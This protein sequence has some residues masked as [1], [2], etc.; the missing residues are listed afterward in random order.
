MNPNVALL[1]LFAMG[2]GSLGL[3]YWLGRR[4][5][6]E[7]QVA[8]LCVGTWGASCLSGVAFRLFMASWGGL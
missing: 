7:G 6:T 5:S 4:G 3:A 1:L 2:A 8:A